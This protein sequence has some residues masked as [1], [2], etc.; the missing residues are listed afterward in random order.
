[1]TM[2]ARKRLKFL[3]LFVSNVTSLMI[4]LELISSLAYFCFMP[5]MVMVAC[6]HACILSSSFGR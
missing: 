5:A 1:V 2:D 3:W 4:L 6:M